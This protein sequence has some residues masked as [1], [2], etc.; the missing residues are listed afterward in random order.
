MYNLIIEVELVEVIVVVK[1]LLVICGGGMCFIGCLVMGE[2]LLMVGLLGIMFYE[3]GVLILVVK[4]GIFMVE[5]EVMLD[6]EN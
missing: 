5:I 1:G 2:I 3:F 6:V 4:V